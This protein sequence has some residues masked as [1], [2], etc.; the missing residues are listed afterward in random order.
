M[1]IP[2][3]HDN[4]GHVDDLLSTVLLWLAPEVALQAVTITNGDC[5]VQ[6][7]YEA[8]LKM[9]T[10]LDLEGAEV[11]YSEDPCVHDFP[12]NWRRESYIINELPIFSENALKKPYQAG[13]PRKTQA[14]IADV[15]AHSRIPVTIVSTG[16]LTN[17]APVFESKPE[18]REKVKEMVIMGGAISVPGNVEQPDHDGSAEWNFYADPAA[19]KSILDSGIPIRLIPLDVTNK[20]PITKEFLTRLDEQAEAYRASRLASKILSLVKGFNYYFWDTLTAA[21]VIEPDLFTY[22]ETKLDVVTHG[23]SQGKTATSFF[24]GR[25]VKLAT[26]LQRDAFA[27]LLLKIFRAF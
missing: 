16:P 25:K 15:L 21:A 10:L 22:K 2:V 11:G 18:L 23:K 5:Y 7:A 9:A 20:A 12:E 27:D 14:L 4:D 8:V 6:Q 19:A 3:I 1:P 26:G 13:K 17:I 24:G